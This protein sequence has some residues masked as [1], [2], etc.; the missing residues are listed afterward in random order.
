MKINL[1]SMNKV[2]TL[3]SVDHYYNAQKY[4]MAPPPLQGNSW[5]LREVVMCEYVF[6][7]GKVSRQQQEPLIIFHKSDRL[8]GKYQ[9][10]YYI[11]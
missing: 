1:T 5:S 6:S 9:F 3:D 11:K 8:G 10:S 7:D 4:I 2:H